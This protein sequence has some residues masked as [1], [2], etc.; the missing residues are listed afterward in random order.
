MAI[1]VPPAGWFRGIA[2]ALFSRYRQALLDLGIT[3]FDVPLEAFLIPDAGRIPDVIDGLRTFRPQCAFGLPLGSYALLCRLPAGRDG[4]R[5]NL[6]TDVLGIP[7]ICLWDHAPVELADQI[8]PSP[9]SD[10]AA[11]TS[12]AQAILHRVL[13]HPLLIHWSRDS[14]QTRIMQALGFLQPNRLIDEL[15]PV[16]PGFQRDPTINGSR[17]GSS[18]G[19]VGHVYQDTPPLPREALTALAAGAIEEWMDGKS[20]RALWDVLQGRIARLPDEERR[21]LALDPD[22]RYFWHFN[23]RLICYQAQTALRLKLLGAARVTVA[24]HGNLRTDTGDIPPNLVPVPTNVPY[25][26]EL[27]T[28]FARHAITIDVLNPGFIHGYSHKQVHGFASGGFML[29]NRKQD[30]VDVFGEAGEAVSCTGA[31]DVAAKVD[32][33][34]T[35]PKQ[36]QEVG[37]AI[38]QTVRSRFELKDVLVR[39]LV[40]A[41]ECMESM[42]LPAPAPL[43]SARRNQTPAVKN[44]LRKLR[45]DPEWPG[46]TVMHG[47]RGGLVSTGPQAWSYAAY[48]PMPAWLK[49]MQEPHL[50]FRLIVQSGRIGLA[51]LHDGTGMLLDEQL[52]SPTADPV[53]VI[54]DLPR[55]GACTVILRNTLDTVSRALVLEASLCDGDPHHG[56]ASTR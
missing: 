36:R 1:T 43:S 7:T 34:L 45:A 39:A 12:G 44:L 52:V 18:V 27:A 38:R 14:G 24:C 25:G 42:D 6:F 37:D 41:G 56:S 33:F 40:R 8:L 31:D 15:P 20:E 49:D 46:A 28:L 17:A 13:S 4:W 19:F 2:G 11:S 55:E 22:D 32:Y 9:P 10:P 47:D 50:R 30:F 26:P 51:A 35:H 3:L 5:P 21:Q 53:T 16:L 23:H 29:M 48:V 54:V